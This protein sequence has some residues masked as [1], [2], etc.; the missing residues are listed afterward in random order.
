MQHKINFGTDGFRAIIAEDFTFA[1]VELIVKSISVYAQKHY[2][3]D[4]PLLVGYDTRFL[5][6]KFA[7]FAAQLLEKFG[8]IVMLSEN[9]IPTPALA[10][11]AKAF[12]SAGAIMFTASHNPPEYCGIKYIPDYAGPATK[13]ITDELVANISLDIQ[14]KNGGKIE[15]FCAKKI[16]FNH[17]KSI[18]DFAK[19]RKMKKNV[20]FDPLYATANGWFDKILSEYNIPIKIIHNWKDPLFGGGM[21]EPKEKYLN[22]LKKIVAETSSAVG[23]SNDGDADRYAVIDE[24]AE[25][26]SPNEI[27]A[28]LLYH[29]L[30]YKHSKG[31]LLKTVA[32][33]LMLN[34]LADFLGVQVIETPVG[35][36]YLGEAMRN[37]PTIIAGEE[38]GGLS[39]GMHIP[40]KDGILANLLVLEAMAYSGKTLVELRQE[41]ADI[42]KVKFINKRFDLK[43]SQKEKEEALNLFLNNSPKE[44]CGKKVVNIS[45]KDGIKF[46]LEGGNDWI[47]IRFSGTEPLLRIYFESLDSDFIEMVYFQ[48]KNMIYS[49]K[50]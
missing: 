21:P 34:K 30:K 5:A 31:I 29:L 32:G 42:T 43:L 6:D 2:G 10:Y 41:I 38:S 37:N 15:K 20:C 18:I 25:F 7:L 9:Y 46:Y 24:N 8:H 22:E 23:F 26:V 50:N 47:L 39:I 48:I 12:N 36:K 11:C 4:K 17:L 35:F 3:I 16:Y 45:K 13:N 44:F 1:N 49:S 40:E 19:I 28:I 27:M 14:Q 33:S